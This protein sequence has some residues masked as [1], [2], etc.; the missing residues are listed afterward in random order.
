MVKKSK[1]NTATGKSAAEF[2]AQV[3]EDPSDKP[4][5]SIK[6]SDKLWVEKFRPKH[7]ENLVGNKYSIALLTNIVKNGNMPNL[8]LTGP[9]GTGKCLGKNTPVLMYDGTVKMVQN[10]KLNG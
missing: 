6:P 4:Q 3:G 7:L 9:P 5:I 8:I 1:S 10:I 2:L